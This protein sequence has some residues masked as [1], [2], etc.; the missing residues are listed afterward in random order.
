[1]T[2]R[3]K[4]SDKRVKGGEKEEEL[5]KLPHDFFFKTERGGSGQAAPGL[6]F[7]VLFSLLQVWQWQ[8]TH[9][10]HPWHVNIFFQTKIQTPKQVLTQGVP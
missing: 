8:Q 1:M 3:G 7:R 9:L 10:L 2:I 5:S 6:G 4:G